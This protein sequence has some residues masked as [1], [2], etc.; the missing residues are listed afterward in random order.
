[1]K[2][3]WRYTGF[4]A[5]I[6]RVIRCSGLHGVMHETLLPAGQ[7]CILMVML[8]SAVGLL[9]MTGMQR[10]SDRAL[11]VTHDERRYW[12]T[13]TLTESSLQWGIGQVCLMGSRSGEQYLKSVT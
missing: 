8:L 10:Q 2:Y 4:V 5:L 3:T 11:Y 12:Q 13:L 7:Q 6:L 9:L 1:M